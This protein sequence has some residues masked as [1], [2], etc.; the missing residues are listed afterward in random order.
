M[1]SCTLHHIRWSSSGSCGTHGLHAI[2][3]TSH[4]PPA[5]IPSHSKLPFSVCLW[6]PSWGPRPWESTAE[7][8]GLI[9]LFDRKWLGCQDTSTAGLIPPHGLCNVNLRTHVRTHTPTEIN[10]Q[11]NSNILM[12]V[13]VWI[14]RNSTNKDYSRCLNWNASL[15]PA[16]STHSRECITMN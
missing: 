12:R 2:V 4:G 11:I 14:I 13:T 15:F 6:A 3:A 1:C 16:V 7:H 5:L 8:R 9:I 10:A